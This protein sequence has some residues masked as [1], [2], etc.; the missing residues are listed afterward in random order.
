MDSFERYAGFFPEAALAMM[1]R[2]GD[3]PSG[4]RYRAAADDTPSADWINL[5]AGAWADAVLPEV[6]EDR[7]P[8]RAE[9]PARGW[10]R[11]AAEGIAHRFRAPRVRA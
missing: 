6:V 7:A 5:R 10:W 3:G 1:E 11:T 4:D 2:Q 8:A 9:A